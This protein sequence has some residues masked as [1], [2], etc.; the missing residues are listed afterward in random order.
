MSPQDSDTGSSTEYRPQA[1]S[2]RDLWLPLILAAVI[3]VV[4]QITKAII[5]ANVPLFYESGFRIEVLGDFLRIIHARNLGIAF[6]IG[7]DLPELL[8]RVLFVGL[9]VVV[10][11][12]LIASFYRSPELSRRQR[13]YVAAI[14]GGGVGNIIDRVAR[15][16]GV[17]DFIDV[18]FYGLFGME[19]WPTFNVADSSVVVGGI[20]LVISMF[21]T[22]D[23]SQ[24]MDTTDGRR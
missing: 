19:R 6:S 1:V 20:L 15:P 23:S 7:N 8:R 17:V 11:I 9:P 22:T 24:R 16:L 10:L 3:V 14:I 21:F 2:R 5:V 4:D 13:W 18:R 12:I